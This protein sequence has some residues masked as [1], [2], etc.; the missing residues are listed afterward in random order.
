MRCFFCSEC[1]NLSHTTAG[2]VSLLLF[3]Y[4]FQ[5]LK[6]NHCKNC[7]NKRIVSFIIKK[8]KQ[9]NV[10]FI[11]DRKDFYAAPISNI[12]VIVILR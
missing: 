11:F 6:K 9:T 2:I 1:L 4:V 12:A 10:T 3:V 5:T 8:K 7:V